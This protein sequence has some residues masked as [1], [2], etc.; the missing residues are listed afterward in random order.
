MISTLAAIAMLATVSSPAAT[1]FTLK[2][3][4]TVYAPN[5]PMSGLI[6]ETT[7]FP[8]EKDCQLFGEHMTER[9]KDWVR[10]RINGDWGLK[11]D[12]TFRCDPAGRG[13]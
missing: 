10:G 5:G 13:T 3:G 4:A 11:V 2:W 12:V 7:K 6:P 9:L 1:G 8:T